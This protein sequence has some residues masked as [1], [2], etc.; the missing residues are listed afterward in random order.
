MNEKLI[1]RQ[2]ESDLLNQALNSGKSE[3]IALIGRRRVGKT[4]LVRQ[5]FGKLL[6][7]E[8][9]GVQHTPTDQQLGNFADKLTQFSHSPFPIQTPDSWLGAF[10]GLRTY[11]S[12]SE[13]PGKKIIFFD[14]LPW[15]ANP[16]SGFLESLGYFW[17][18]WAG[19]NNV[20]IIL[21]GSSA[22]WMI[23]QVMHHKGSLHNR[24][25]VQIHL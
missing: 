10:R 21:C 8:L 13:R 5:I 14:E 19:H 15:I 7:F 17:N 1:G 2:E 22:G 25:T 18:D 6:D 11:L 4:F 24:I 9:T 12:N 23:R 20:V 16:K 3:L